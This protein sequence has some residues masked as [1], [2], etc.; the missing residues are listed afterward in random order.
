MLAHIWSLPHQIEWVLLGVSKNDRTI[1]KL[2]GE[3]NK[4]NLEDK[5]FKGKPRTQTLK[6][7]WYSLEETMRATRRKLK[8]KKISNW[9]Y[10]WH[11][12]QTK[13]FIFFHPNPHHQIEKPTTQPIILSKTIYPSTISWLGVQITSARMKKWIKK[14]TILLKNKTQIKKKKPHKSIA[15]KPPSN[16]NP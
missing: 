3:M 8:K 14:I 4:K 12:L 11:Q 9:Y 16:F 7:K 6:L 2:M 1:N 15:K 10:Q 5:L 13:F